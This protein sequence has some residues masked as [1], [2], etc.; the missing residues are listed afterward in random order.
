MQFCFG[1]KINR[2]AGVE[3]SW[4]RDMAEGI[5]LGKRDDGDIGYTSMCSYILKFFLN[6]DGFQ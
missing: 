3:L 6:D 4:D 2:R 1:P 5:R